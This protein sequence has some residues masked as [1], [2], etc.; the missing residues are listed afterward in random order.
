M[1]GTQP[2]R[3]ERTSSSGIAGGGGGPRAGDTPT[4]S[5]PNDSAWMPSTESLEGPPME[6]RVVRE[7]I[8]ARLFPGLTSASASDSDVLT[9]PR[10]GRFAILR[11]LGQGGMGVVFLAYDE[12][13]DRKVALK[14]LR[15]ARDP[16]RS[17]ARLTREAQ[18]LARL[19][20]PNVVGIHEI[21]EHDGQVY[22]AMEYVRG[23]T[24]RRWLE[25]S[26]RT[27]REVL[28]VL[29]QAGRGLEAAHAAGLVHRDF[30]PDNVLVGDDGRVRVVDF[31][32]VRVD[33]HA[34]IESIQDSSLEASLSL[35]GERALG[36]SLTLSGSVLGTPMY[37]PLEQQQGG[38]A[39]ALGDQYSFC[40]TAWET[41]HGQRPFAGDTHSQ[42]VAAQQAMQLREPPSRPR[43][44]TPPRSLRLDLERG[45]DC[46]PARRWPNLS[47]LLARLEAAL[48][49]RRRTTT[50]MLGVGVI[51]ATLALGLAAAWTEAREQPLCEIGPELLAGSWDADAA[52][53]V[54]R[55]FAATKLPYA[56][57]AEHLVRAKLDAWSSEWLDVQRRAC[58]ATRVDKVAS[59]QLLDRHRVCLSELQAE[60]DGVVAILRTADARVV[61]RSA[62]L[63]DRLPDPH[64]CERAA[65]LDSIA[66]G[67]SAGSDPA[68]LAAREQLGR[69]RALRLAGR[70]DEA[71][72]RGRS[73]QT[74][75][76]DPALLREAEAELGLVELAFGREPGVRARTVDRLRALAGEAERAGDAW[77]GAQLRT[78]LAEVAADKLESP[79]FERWLLD[80]A[81]VALGRV[82]ADEHRLAW[83]SFAEARVAQHDGALELAITRY[84]ELLEQADARGWSNLA[85]AVSLQLAFAHDSRGELDRASAGYAD[86]RTRA[87]A[88]FGE[89]HPHLADVDLALAQHELALGRT[90]QAGALLDRAEAILITAPGP[91]LARAKVEAARAHLA[92]QEGRWDAALALVESALTIS[93]RELGRD[94]EETARLHELRATLR[95]F[96]GD[97]AGALGDYEH[98]RRVFERRFDPGHETLVL[99]WANLGDTLLALGHRQEAQRAFE[100]SLAHLDLE[101]GRTH[102]L[103]AVSLAGLGEIALAEGRPDAAIPNLEAALALLDGHDGDAAERAATQLSLSRALI[104]A[105]RDPER[106]RTLA[107]QARST[108]S[109]LGLPEPSPD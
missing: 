64:A 10:V 39:D 91:T 79:K 92:A 87:L 62:V 50:A 70:A 96:V 94:H 97:L 67:R 90:E 68:L 77:F 22:I 102:P 36:R 48:A 11:K 20:H 66:A 52:A 86:A 35:S 30:K 74:S 93:T 69:A 89:G 61:E 25:A 6:A 41:L 99:V 16:Q 63:I 34:T 4:A 31:G 83:L 100:E 73:V 103:T 78:T 23:Q 21:G 53:D 58:V 2:E 27:W 28:A 44:L 46:D 17:R 29:L 47:V 60:F 37:M 12:Q 81:R 24:L 3:G 49:P 109:A 54:Q 8:K 98:A 82:D 19:S 14:L 5:A 45:L 7:S 106:A 26:P 42:L 57:S 72:A 104:A 32:L 105:D 85:S 108:L 75:T 18:A 38:T 1:S 76:T 56:T 9:I 101:L 88:V 84:T 80:D 71:A 51:G 13:L 59:E 40:F 55:S 43:A 107:D 15:R 33:E 65:V 95:F